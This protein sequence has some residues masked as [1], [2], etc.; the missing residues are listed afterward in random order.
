MRNRIEIA[1]RGL[2]MGATVVITAAL[3]TV[4]VLE[5]GRAKGLASAAGKHLLEITEEIK[6]S[7]VTRYDGMTVTGSEVVNFCRK[8]V[9]RTGANDEGRFDIIVSDGKR[10]ISCYDG[11]TVKE[12]RDTGSASYIKPVWYYR[13]EVITNGNNVITEVKFTRII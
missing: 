9:G 8:H 6:N 1:A 13:C 3:V 7:D 11:Q 12:M 4:G 10:S 2:L 5:M